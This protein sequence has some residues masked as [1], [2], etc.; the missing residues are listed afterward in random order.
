[1]AYKTQD[2]RKFIKANP[3]GSA[4][5]DRR[6]ARADIDRILGGTQKREE[7]FVI[8]PTG[9]ET[10]S[11]NVPNFMGGASPVVQRGRIETTMVDTPETAEMRKEMRQA[12]MSRAQRMLDQARGRETGER[13]FYSGALGRV[14]EALDPRRRELQDMRM[15]IAQEGLGADV[16]QAGREARL[17]GLQRE[18][19]QQQRALRGMQGATGVFGGLAGAQQ[20]GLMEQQQRAR[21][22][23]ERQLLLDDATQRQQAMGAAEQSVAAGEAD[24]L[25]RQQY[26]LAQRKAEIMGR[27]TAEYG[28]AALGVAERSSAKAAQAAKDYGAAVAASGGGGKK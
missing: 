16:F 10:R 28:E 27:L 18:Q 3:G 4:G 12:E 8:D 24:I 17:G 19:Q 15:Q 13:E 20:M 5:A 21:Q 6:A 11:H 9:T 1:M 7:R 22:D 23:A 26:N 14:G 2:M 25:G